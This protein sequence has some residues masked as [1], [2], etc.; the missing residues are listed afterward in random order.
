MYEEVLFESFHGNAD[1]LPFLPRR[2][3]SEVE[4]EEKM[5]IEAEVAKI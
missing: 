4:R 1:V 5:E 2:R 3:W